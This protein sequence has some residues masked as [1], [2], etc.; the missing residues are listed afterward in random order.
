MPLCDL[1]G[2]EAKLTRTEIEKARL[3]VCPDC[4]KYGKKMY[5]DV[6]FSKP[7]DFDEQP[8]RRQETARKPEAQ[9]PVFQIG[10]QESQIVEGYGPL[11]RMARDR[12]KLTQGELG[13]AIAEKENTIQRIESGQQEPTPK[14]AKKLEQFLRISLITK[15]GPKEAV[16][17]NDVDFSETDLTIGD[18]LDLSKDPSK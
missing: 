13:K 18:L 17:L 12:A 2:K 1:C 6:D 10:L 8:A 7:E 15:A 3:N 11:V 16:V 5:T 9:R 4:A 14:I